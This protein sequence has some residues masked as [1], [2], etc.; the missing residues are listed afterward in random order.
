MWKF[1]L[2]SV[3]SLLPNALLQAEDYEDNQT[4][5]PYTTQIYQTSDSHLC[6]EHEVILYTLMEPTPLREYGFFA[7]PFRRAGIRGSLRR[8]TKTRLELRQVC[9]PGY[10]RAYDNSCHPVST[11]TEIY[12]ELN[13]VSTLTV[14]VP[15]T[16]KSLPSAAD[17][18]S[19]KPKPWLMYGT[20]LI[21]ILLALGVCM[22]SFYYIKQ[23][24][25]KRNEDGNEIE[26]RSALFC[27]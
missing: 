23:R 9:C 4:E 11:T 21:L 10:L 24:K 12:T 27:N 18:Q 13:D 6:T 20:V 19:Y 8:V 15:S 1:V 2:I 7:E 26:A 17:K 5:L 16:D 3:L 25:D 14:P 22:Y